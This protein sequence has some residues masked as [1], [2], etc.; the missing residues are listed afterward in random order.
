MQKFSSF[1]DLVPP[2]G[3]LPDVE[4][5]FLKLTLQNIL[6]G[7]ASMSIDQMNDFLEF[8]SKLYDVVF[9]SL[10]K[11]DIHEILL[12]A[13]TELVQGSP[14]DIER[15]PVYK[16]F[17][18]DLF[19][20]GVIDEKNTDLSSDL[21]MSDFNLAVPIFSSFALIEFTKA[22]DKAKTLR[23]NKKRLDD[24]YYRL[25][26]IYIDLKA[27]DSLLNM[28]SMMN[29]EISAIDDKEKND[30]ELHRRKSS[31]GGANSYK[32]KLTQKKTF[33]EQYQSDIQ[34]QAIS[35]RSQYVSDYVKNMNE[36][37]RKNFSETNINRY[38]LDAI[39]DFEKGKYP[40]EFF[41]R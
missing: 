41:D 39:R 5:E 13:I 32:D 6:H 2:P 29:Q 4:T 40:P 9:R 36:S 17:N 1:S 23:Q 25:G 35:N 38:F 18:E 19:D 8:N 33:L 21:L 37:D 12:N 3:L 28:M 30:A 20:N 26:K 16:L 24:P 7:L 22:I 27:V 14:S 11:P 15:L 34:N 31:K 10:D